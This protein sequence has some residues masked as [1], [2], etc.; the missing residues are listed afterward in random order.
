MPPS[1]LA[2]QATPGQAPTEDGQNFMEVIE[3]LAAAEQ[4][5]EQNKNAGGNKQQPP[6]NPLFAGGSEPAEETAE[7][8]PQTVHDNLTP[9]SI[10]KNNPEENP[11]GVRLDLTA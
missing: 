9:P 1:A 4:S 11:L 3:S 6:P 10:E 8:T 7:E 2:Q 5:P